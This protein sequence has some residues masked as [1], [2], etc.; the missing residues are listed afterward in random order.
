M[1]DYYNKPTA[2]AK[3]FNSLLRTLA[4]IGLT[5]RDN[6]VVQV[7]GRKSGKLRSNV[8]TYVEHEGVRYLVAPRGT[9]DWVRNVRA[10]DGQA[11]LK[12]GKAHQVKLTEMPVEQRTPI[13]HAYLQKMPEMVQREFGVSRSSSGDEIGKIAPRHPVFRITEV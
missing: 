1:A 5:P 3:F 12:H 7:R 13:I 6:I 2:L 4:G 8:V 11:S 10:A 9:T